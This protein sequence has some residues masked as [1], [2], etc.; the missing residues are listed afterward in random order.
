MWAVSQLREAG[1]N[2]IRRGTYSLPFEFDVPVSSPASSQYPADGK[3]NF[4]CRIEYSLLAKIGTFR[5]SRIVDVA[6]AP[7]PNETSP[8]L[9]QPTT[10][11]LKSCGVLKRG[12]ITVGASVADS[13]IGRGQTLKIS[14]ASRNDASVN[15]ERVCVKLVELIDYKAQEEEDTR[16]V[17]LKKLKDIDL[18]CL[19]KAR[20][21]RS[22][23]RENSQ[24]GVEDNIEATYQAIYQD[25]VSGQ[26]QVDLQIPYSARETYSGKLMT[27]S[28][29]LKVTFFTTSLVQNPSTKIPIRI[30]N[31][32]QR[33]GSRPSIPAAPTATSPIATAIAEDHIHGSRNA[34]D[35]PEIEV[36][37][38]MVN[39]VLLDQHNNTVP[40]R[41]SSP[42][43]VDDTIVVGAAVV[44]PEANQNDE[45]RS[46]S[47]L[48]ES[49]ESDSDESD[50]GSDNFEN[51]PPATNEIQTT[52]SLIMLVQELR[53]S[54]NGH[55]VV[56]AKTRRPEWLDF[57]ARLT[58]D[59]F[60][61]ILSKI[62]M[63]HQIRAAALLAKHIPTNRFTCAHCV[64]AIRHTSEYF[65]SNM[66]EALL[67]YCCDLETEHSLIQDSLSEWEQVITGRA[68]EDAIRKRRSR[69]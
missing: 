20:K 1:N 48:L 41:A 5:L 43:G 16:K 11:Q 45:S 62:K 17:E 50:T 9:V 38:P 29:Y 37:I 57:F 68:F 61:I 13:Y 24:G 3:R 52:P 69:R 6:S 53:D 14:I 25:L 66:V 26:N 42:R 49:D 67:Q 2:K 46:V 18:P 21:S 27:I 44:L 40:E 34:S 59:E 31:P 54:T 12:S 65:R 39:A 33:T 56:Y 22:E 19:I 30:G 35:E 15:I 51:L 58:S 55:E 23:R 32:S 60:G 64:A 4:D 7:L 10:Y 47:I 28:H 63:D 8:C 36:E